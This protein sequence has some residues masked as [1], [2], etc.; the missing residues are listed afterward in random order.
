MTLEKR[1]YFRIDDTINMS[2]SILKPQV[3]ELRLSTDVMDDFE[4]LEMV[5][6]EL[7]TLTN[8]LWDSDPKLAKAIGL[9]NQKLNLLTSKTR[10]NL[11]E[12]MANYDHPFPDLDVNI[13]ASGMAFNCDVKVETGDRLD[14]LLILKPTCTPLKLK[15]AVVNAEEQQLRKG[16]CY[17]ICV[18][19][20]VGVKEKEQL[21]QHIARRQVET[22]GAREQ[23]G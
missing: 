4:M 17:F 1:R 12:L 20:D 18:E 8:S 7:D 9:L 14:M 10:P 2:F 21:I 19:F 5:D 11:D 23:V 16:S 6:A 13:S 3:P 15:C 22:I